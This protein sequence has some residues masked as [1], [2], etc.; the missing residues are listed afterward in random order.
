MRHCDST[1]NSFN[2]LMDEVFYDW[3]FSHQPQQLNKA[4][5]GYWI[6][7]TE[8]FQELDENDQLIW[9]LA[10][11]TS[12]FK[13]DE[14]AMSHFKTFFDFYDNDKEFQNALN[15]VENNWHKNNFIISDDKISLG[16]LEFV[17]AP[18]LKYYIKYESTDLELSK[19]SF[20][21]LRKFAEMILTTTT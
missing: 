12:S 2:E 16:K 15:Y 1:L 19:K 7:K 10:Y 20:Q 18:D 17:K 11:K 13:I 4:D 8:I 3:G 5:R 6:N 14:Q 21:K 9:V